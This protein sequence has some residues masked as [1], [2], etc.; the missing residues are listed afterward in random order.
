M[1]YGLSIAISLRVLGCFAEFDGS[2]TPFAA[3]GA[4]GGY[5]GV[6]G[7]ATRRGT[8]K[9]VGI[10]IRVTFFGLGRVH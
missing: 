8:D 2:S 1:T 6:H 5:V 4:E 10:T 7:A 9:G 3:T